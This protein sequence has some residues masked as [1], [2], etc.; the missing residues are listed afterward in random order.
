[1]PRLNFIDRVF[2]FIQTALGGLLDATIGAVLLLL[3]LIQRDEQAHD[4]A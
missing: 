3:V 1:V 2:N 4:A